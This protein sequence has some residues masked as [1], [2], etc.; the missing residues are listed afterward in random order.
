[1]IPPELA[2][3]DETMRCFTATLNAIMQK[4][5]EII[6]D[7]HGTCCL[8]SG[9]CT[10]HSNRIYKAAES[11]VKVVEQMF[12]SEILTATFA[13]MSFMSNVSSEDVPK[14]ISKAAAVANGGK[15]AGVG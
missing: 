13:K 7:D 3:S 14:K 8:A 12:E 4:R 15:S 11:F 6:S 5:L 1:M 10:V 2:G 9:L